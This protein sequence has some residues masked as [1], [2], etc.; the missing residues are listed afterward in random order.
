[1]KIWILNIVGVSLFGIL[2]EI[3]LPTGSTNKYIKGILSLVL[4]YVIVSPL[5]SI[6][7]DYKMGDFKDFFNNDIVVDTEFVNGVNITSNI[8]EEKNIECILDNE[9]YKNVNVNIISN[10]IS[11]NK[12]EFVKISLKNLVIENENTN[13][14]I[15]EKISLIVSRRLK[16]DS[17]R[18]YYE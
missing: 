13:I 18:I 7:T 16:I 17:N 4:V 15:K 1:M 12:I 9:G 14:D 11:Q 10:A 3:L 2:I 5:I 8:Q 6:F